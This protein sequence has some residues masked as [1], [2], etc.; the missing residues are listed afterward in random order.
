M[1]AVLPNSGR[2]GTLR[3]MGSQNWCL[4]DPR[5]LQIQSPRVQFNPLGSNDSEGIQRTLKSL[6]WEASVGANSFTD[7]FF[8]AWIFHWLLRTTLTLLLIYSI[9]GWKTILSF[10]APP[11]CKG[12]NVSLVGGFNPIWKISVK[13]DHFPRDENKQCL[14]PPPRIMFDTNCHD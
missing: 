11:I 13:L 2:A 1:G 7:P 5:S 12:K 4:G 6:S 10:E 8:W 3:I 9:D 14:K